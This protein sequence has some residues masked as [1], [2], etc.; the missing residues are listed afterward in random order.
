MMT[1]S[2][3]ILLDFNQYLDKFVAIQP[4]RPNLL[5]DKLV[6]DEELSYSLNIKLFSDITVFLKGCFDVYTVLIKQV[7]DLVLKPNE[8]Y[9]LMQ[10]ITRARM[11]VSN[12]ISSTSNFQNNYNFDKEVITIFKEL[13]TEWIKRGTRKTKNGGK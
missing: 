13:E 1:I 6:K 8:F 5:A 9:Q 12:L 4:P 7:D 10:F 3:T 11:N 2:N